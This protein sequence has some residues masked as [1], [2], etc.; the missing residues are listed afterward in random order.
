MVF[1]FFSILKCK[2]TRKDSRGSGGSS[3]IED[4]YIFGGGGGSGSETPP[5]PTP[6]AITSCNPGYVLVN[7]ECVCTTKTKAV[8]ADN[9]YDTLNGHQEYEK[10][11][12]N[13]PNISIVDPYILPLG[14]QFTDP[15]S[16][17]NSTLYKITNTDGSVE[18]VY[19]TEGTVSLT[20]WKNNFQQATGYAAKQY[21][22][23]VAN[24]TLLAKWAAEN[25]VTLSFTGHSLGGGLANANALATGLK[26][27]IYNPA[28]LSEGTINNDSR[29]DLA[30]SSNVTAYVVR[31]EPVDAANRILDT[32]VRAGTINY[33]GTGNATTE[34]LVREFLF[35][36]PGALYN[37]Y[38]LHSMEQ[39]LLDI[40]CN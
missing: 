24:A 32:P 7:C 28:G 19:A 1:V 5:A 16:S 14:I 3:S 21:I 39:V 31:G 25:H 9:V 11:Q 20:D 27:T 22:L 36:P 8:I 2:T 10:P 26:A 29:L 4:V 17:F 23:S 34:Q 33:I 37:Q 15:Y 40:N 12:I 13:S 30:N 6:C 18:Y 38:E 35:G